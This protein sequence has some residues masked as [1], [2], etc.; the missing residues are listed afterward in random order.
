[1]WSLPRCYEQDSEKQRVRLSI[2]FCKGCRYNSVD[3]RVVGYSPES[4]DVRT[5]AEESPLLRAVAK[6][7]LVTTLQ[8]GEDL[9]CGDLDS[10]RVVYSCGH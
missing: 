4:N 7:R 3:S 10:V 5:E 9:A 8:A 6:Q 1:M 2:E